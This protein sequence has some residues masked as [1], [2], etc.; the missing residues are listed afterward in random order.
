MH[1]LKKAFLILP[2]IFSPLAFASVSVQMNSTTDTDNKGVAKS[3]GTIDLKQTN[4]GVL[5]IPNLHGLPPG[6]HGFHVHENA[7]CADHGNA[8]GGHFDPKDTKKHLGPYNHE[9]HLGDSPVLNVDKEGNSTIPVL[10]PRMRLSELRGH[11]LII[12]AGADNYSDTPEK[13]GGGGAR[14]AC[15]IINE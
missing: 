12:H 1:Y 13:L 2:F 4:Y 9:G 11:A 10:A 6:V 3:F 5:F 8:A 7:S 14:I 15:G